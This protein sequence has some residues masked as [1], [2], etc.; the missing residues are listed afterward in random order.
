MEEGGELPRL[1][2]DDDHRDAIG[3]HRWFAIRGTSA[4]RAA[5][6]FTTSPEWLGDPDKFTFLATRDDETIAASIMQG[7]P[8]RRQG[9][10][11]SRGAGKDVQL[12]DLCAGIG[13]VAAVAGRLGFDALSV[14]LSV[15]P[16][17]I[18]QVLHEFAVSM[19]RPSGPAAN[20]DKTPVTGWR[21]FA[22]EVD[23][24]A[25]AVWSGAKERLKD[26]FEEDVDTRIW[27]RI[28]PCPSCAH[29]VPVLSNARL[30]R[31]TALDISAGSGPGF[32]G[33]F[34]RFDLLRTESDR[35]G[36]FGRGVCTCPSCRFRFPFAGPELISLR[37][38]PVAVRMRDSAT[39]T[40][41]VSPDIYITH[42]EAAAYRSIA[43]SS[44]SL[45]NRTILGDHQAIFHDARGE[46]ISVREALLPRQRAYFAALA[47]SMDRQSAALEKR[48]EITAEHRFAVRAAV[49]L[50][51]S[52][53]IDYINTFIHS[54]IDKPGPSASAG[55]L[56]LGGLF[57][58]FGGHWLERYWQTRLSHLL[59]LLR[60]G[61]SSLRA[62]RAVQADAAAIPLGDASVSAVVWDPPYYDNV[63]YDTVG[64]PFQ[65]ILAAMLPDAVSALAVPPRLP[66]GERKE[67][68][69]RE[70]LR[71]AGEA[72]RVVRKDGH[73]GVFW[74]AS[75]PAELEHFL[76]MVAP[77][78]LVLLSA[79]RLDTIRVARVGAG[80]GPVTYLLVLKP[81]QAAA[82]AV[83]VDAEKV[84]ALAAAGAVSLY[85]GLAEL[86]ESVWSP[87]DLNRVIP[88]EQQGS[89]RR[90]LV[91]FLA[92][93]PEPEKLLVD[94]LGRIVL[95][96]ELV[97]RGADGDELRAV[98]AGG[99]AQR[100]L[101]E[102]GFAVPRPV[103]FSIRAALRECDIARSGLELAVTPE[104]FRG[105]F[106]H[107]CDLIERILR[108]ATLSWSHL[109][110]GSQWES[111]FDEIVSAGAFGRYR[112]P[113]DLHFGEWKLLLVRLP[114]VFSGSG[115][116]FNKEL[117]GRVSRAFK[118]AKVDE[119]LSELISLRNSVDH[120]KKGI[121][122]LS[123][124][125]RR[126]RCA[127]ALADACA[128]LDDL[129]AR[130]LLPL[131]VRPEEE[132]RDR[133][134]RR[135]LRLR[136]P[137]GVAIE[138]YVSSE[139]D[140]TEPLIYFASDS[141]KRAIDPR[142]LRAAVVEELLGLT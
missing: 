95:V 40:E 29:Q 92:S 77:A 120:T 138:A 137:D 132:R 64:E 22:A 5:V 72:R 87:A 122:A 140:L 96:H 65:A 4:A 43:A 127:K 2:L 35:K 113:D 82:P 48:A 13:T 7:M 52:G 112:S 83:V 116:A 141:S 134:G 76:D 106:F 81:S 49:A 128:I 130:Q 73:V 24:F 1:L 78:G 105:T 109:A 45:G 118:K 56:Q 61:A 27:V 131:T 119:K 12:L 117:F 89:P 57:T 104:V 25:H 46:P 10:A 44:R 30:S 107:C 51:I 60:A 54:S 136:D 67:R 121:A 123:L 70:L 91:G 28:V 26:L 88:G 33:A 31:D 68:Y 21:G 11:Q 102:F 99:L 115:D 108:Y 85:E 142:F 39:L 63:D 135:I 53:Q 50:L 98:E 90:R 75:N 114:A 3:F 20:T 14:E 94:E 42:T 111:A 110:L 101:G 9:N 36:T 124:A 17:L 6:A 34:P 139:T 47:E 97:K 100:L 8:N 125:E 62:V 37:S 71:Q 86:L 79:V 80:T 15:V 66:P 58:E 74:L 93:H 32:E 126:A 84:L 133:Y 59:G 38:V 103:R 129:D 55:S 41:I 16:H 23:E 19:A 18:N 69:E